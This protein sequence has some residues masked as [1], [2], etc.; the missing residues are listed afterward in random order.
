MP[1]I[2]P[3]DSYE[4]WLGEQPGGEAELLAAFSMP[5]VVVAKGGVT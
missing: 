3:P 5:D 4:K 2:L 1:E